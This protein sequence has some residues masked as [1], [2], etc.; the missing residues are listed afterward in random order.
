P[1]KRSPNYIY[2]RQDVDFNA[3]VK[4]LTENLFKKYDGFYG[5]KTEQ[6]PLFEQYKFVRQVCNH[7]VINGK[8]YKV[9][10]SLWDFMFTRL[11]R[12][13]KRVLDFGID[14][15]FGERNTYGF[16]FVNVR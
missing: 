3:F 8:E 6:F 11:G 2:W 13:Q 10:G 7:L 15:G 5:V 1:E 12:E 16:G 14:C 4:Q 9:I